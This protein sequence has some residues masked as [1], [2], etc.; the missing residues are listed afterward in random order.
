MV[1]GAL[2]I[3]VRVGTGGI[4]DGS[5]VDTV[6]KDISKL[7]NEQVDTVI[8]DRLESTKKD[9]L[10]IRNFRKYLEGFARKHGDG[11][12]IVFIIDE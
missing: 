6:E 5:E 3:G 4:L 2:K 10:A 11:M 12:P 9:K 8:A 1:R 7:W